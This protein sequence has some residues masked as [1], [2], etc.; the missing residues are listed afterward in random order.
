MEILLVGIITGTLNP[1]SHRV[2]TVC[3]AD[4][5][6]VTGSRL[7]DFGQ[8][9][10]INPRHT[11]RDITGAGLCDTG[12]TDVLVLNHHAITACMSC[13]AVGKVEFEAKLGHIARVPVGGLDVT[14]KGGTAPVFESGIRYLLRH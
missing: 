6:F 7:A 5:A 14:V 3:P 2:R 1:Y 9:L 8:A 12:C 13:F 11:K 4:T 10:N